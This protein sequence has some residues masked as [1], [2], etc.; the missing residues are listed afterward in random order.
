MHCILGNIHLTHSKK[1][2]ICC[3]FTLIFVIIE[4]SGH[5][6]NDNFYTTNFLMPNP[7]VNP[8]FKQSPFVLSYKNSVL[9]RVCNSEWAYSYSHTLIS[10]FMSQLS[11][12]LFLQLKNNRLPQKKKKKLTSNSDSASKN[13]FTCKKKFFLF[14]LDA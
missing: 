4:L 3:G 13:T 12:T 5:I 8:V 14:A 6:K 9:D 2:I 11:D 10:Y 7:N 1:K